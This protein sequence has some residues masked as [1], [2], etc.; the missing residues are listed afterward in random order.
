M[1][2]N[3]DKIR[4]A[5]QTYNGQRQQAEARIKQIKDLYGPEAAQHE[6]ERQ[7]KTL[8]QARTTAEETIRTAHRDG[9]SG[10][11]AWGVLDGSKLTDDARLLDAGLVDAEAFKDMKTRYKDNFTMLSALRNYGEKQNAAAAE[12][13]RKSGDIFG[14]KMLEPF[15]TRDIPTANSKVERWDKLQASALDTLDAIDGVGRY[16]DDWNKSFGRAALP[17]RL[18]HFGEDM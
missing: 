9:R 8:K 18:E 4:K 14:G 2:A 16:S 6:Q 5:L 12:E 10:A 13:A 1:N 15:E 11:A 17:E 7:D 3:A